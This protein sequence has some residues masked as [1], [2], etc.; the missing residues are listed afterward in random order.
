M[1]VIKSDS[2]YLAKG[3][4]ERVFKWQNNGYQTCKGTPVKNWELFKKLDGLIRNLNEL[5]VEVL[6]WH[7][8]R[9]RNTEADELAS[10][11]LRS[12]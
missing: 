4:T 2:E 1:V 5:D 7:V 8:P 12:Q 10:R 6:F 3:M 9:S 11:A